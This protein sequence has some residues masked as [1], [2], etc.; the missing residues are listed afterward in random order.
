MIALAPNHLEM[1]RAILREYL[2]GKTVWAYG[3]RVTG[4]SHDGSDLDLV[5]MPPVS[6]SE[7]SAVRDA[8][9]ESDLPVLVDI[10]AWESIPAAFKT[11]IEKTHEVLQQ[12][13]CKNQL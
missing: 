11:D 5:V 7:L 12:P 9:S 2:P 3:S 4:T 8:F 6:E 1:T 13:C 10:F